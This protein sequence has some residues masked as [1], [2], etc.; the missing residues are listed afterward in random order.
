MSE[1]SVYEM[2]SGRIVMTGRSLSLPLDKIPVADGRAIVAGKWPADTHYIEGGSP[3]WRPTNPAM[4]DKSV[5]TADLIDAITIAGVPV[6]SVAV[7]S[8]A[9][10][11]CARYAVDDGALVY[12]TATPGPKQIMLL[13]F[14][15]RDLVFKIDVNP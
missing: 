13:S 8:G 10:I 5:L 14:P 9:G 3:V 4:I 11:G 6:A 2:A 15:Y 12:Q 7:I 1:Y